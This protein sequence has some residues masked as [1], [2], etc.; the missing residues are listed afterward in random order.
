M[1]FARKNIVPA[2][3]SPPSREPRCRLRHDGACCSGPVLCHGNWVSRKERAHALT[4]PVQTPVRPPRHSWCPVRPE[5]QKKRAQ[6]SLLVERTSS[7]RQCDA[8]TVMAMGK[9]FYTL[10]NFSCCSHSRALLRAV[11]LRRRPLVRL[12]TA[13]G[14]GDK[15]GNRN[16]RCIRRNISP[17]HRASTR[18]RCSDT[19]PGASHSRAVPSSAT[20]LRYRTEG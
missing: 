7:F 1:A 6:N 13:P 17:S 2:M 5:S 4:S 14:A 9:F 10:P 11:P 19:A 3:T 12:Q 15:T 16:T 8:L 18:D 20:T